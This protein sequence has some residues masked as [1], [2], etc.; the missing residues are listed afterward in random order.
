MF[1]NNSIISYIFIPQDML[2]DDGVFLYP[3]FIDAAH[4]HYEIFYK[5]LNVVYL[6]LFNILEVPVTQCPLNLNSQGLPIGI[7][8]NTIPLGIRYTTNLMTIHVCAKLLIPVINFP[9]MT[10]Y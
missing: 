8:V 2:G 10:E 5:L 6:C 1:T 4:I 3:T 7:Q 9:L